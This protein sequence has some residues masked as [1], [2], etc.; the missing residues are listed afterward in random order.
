[1]S[2]FIGLLIGVIVGALGTVAVA[3]ILYAAPRKKAPVRR[4][5]AERMEQ[6][7]QAGLDP[8]GSPNAHEECYCGHP[9]FA[10]GGP[11][12]DKTCTGQGEYCP[13]MGFNP[14]KVAA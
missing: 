11:R 7:R 3:M 13:C 12:M 8:V 6:M 4:D 9:R 10:H 5:E 2:V 1:M 14:R